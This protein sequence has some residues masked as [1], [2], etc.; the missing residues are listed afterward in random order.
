MAMTRESLGRSSPAWTDAQVMEAVATARRPHAVDALG[1]C[2]LALQLA[3]EATP[4]RVADIVRDVI[5]TEEAMKAEV[6]RGVALGKKSAS[7]SAAKVRML[8]PQG[9]VRARTHGRT[10]LCA[11]PL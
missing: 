1:D 4:S 3:A 8:L 9:V 2:A 5:D 11:R 10:A 7:P 6:I